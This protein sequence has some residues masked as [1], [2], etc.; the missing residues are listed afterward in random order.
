MSQ[1]CE[2]GRLHHVAKLWKVREA[3]GSVGT[4]ASFPQKAL[5]VPFWVGFCTSGVGWVATVSLHMP[6]LDLTV[7][8]LPESV[9]EYGSSFSLWTSTR[10]AGSPVERS[11]ISGTLEG[12]K[13]WLEMF[14]AVSELLV[15]R[16]H[17]QGL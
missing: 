14:Q 1:N 9:W 2:L 10:R 8:P 15:I 4:F 16:W 7:R 3:F 11:S 17:S 13:L 5:I 6:R 12:G